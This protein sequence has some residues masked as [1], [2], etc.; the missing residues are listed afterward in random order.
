VAALAAPC[1]AASADGPAGIAAENAAL[2]A[3]IKATASAVD[4]T[5]ADLAR[6]RKRQDDLDEALQLIERRA[7]VHAL[8]REFAQT[9][10][11]RLHLLPR[12]EQFA[13]ARDERIGLLESTSD[14][15]L[16]VERAL[17]ELR[18]LDAAVAKS[19]VA[20]APVAPPQRAELEATVR[21]RL[22]EQR[23]LLGELNELQRKL[24]SALSEAEEAE[25]ALEQRGETART[26]L[27][28]LLFWIPTLPSTRTLGGL[29][30]ALAWTA[31]AANWRA[32]GAA[33]ADELA[34]RPVWPTLVVLAAVALYVLRGRLERMLGALAPAAV[35]YEHYRIGHALAALAITFALAAPGPIVLW[36]A[37]ALLRS[38]SSAP[39]FAQ[40]LGDALEVIARPLLAVLALAWL[41]D[42]RGMAVRH[43][44][45][46]EAAATF[47]ATA[48]RRFLVVF[49][50]LIFV[51]AL[52][53]LDHA[54]YG[55][56]ESLSRFAF[57][58]AMIVLAVFLIYLLRRRSTLTRRLFER[59]PTSWAARLHGLW[60]CALV[61]LPIGLGALSVAGYFVAASFFFGRLMQSLFFVLGALMFYG[62]IALWV[63][64]Q[65]A[66][67]ERRREAR[68]AVPAP[69]TADAEG[70]GALAQLRPPRLDIAAISDQTRSLL[71]LLITLLLLGGM[72]WLWKDALPVLSVIGDYPL[73]TYSGDSDGKASHLLTV[74]GLFHVL[75]VA[76]VTAI[77][78]RDVGAL[79][80]MALLQRLALQADATYAIKV[81]TRYALVA[82]GIVLS[83]NILGV[84]WRDVQWLVAALGVGLGFGL[85]EIFANFVSGL[86]VLAERPVRIGDVVTVGEV[87][88]TV[89]RIRARATA[90]IDFDNREVIIPNK[91]FITERVVNWT[92]TDQTTRLLVKVGVAY[93]SDIA[94]VQRVLG[95][96]LAAMPEILRQP[97][98]SV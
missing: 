16:R 88:G 83:A 14:A 77:A 13:N 3:E 21:E 65:H 31:A 58:L 23:G 22:V 64:V 42:R 70:G 38:A 41:L 35:G 26:E 7:Q 66:R 75:L 79:L 37:G 47:T 6:L 56:R 29:A 40:A 12:A 54:P 11:E 93:G 85:Q 4:R 72:W 53:G 44:G 73:W 87:T 80:D 59:A 94:L 20:P 78:V 8:G 51:A 95:D 34:W 18:D 49:L 5:L 19:V 60:L 81:V 15:N 96:A 10:I 71:D 33:L 36:T 24:L 45:W 61:A 62:V 97:P 48:L 27:T 43:F 67:L 90:I 50:P 2:E 91:S 68:S 25:H 57:N 86:I 98:H 63:Q 55:N 69:A 52:N 92:L 82:I 9:V 76:A 89:A 74:G 17:A 32:A 46:N 28:R 84:G 1:V 30:P 39:P